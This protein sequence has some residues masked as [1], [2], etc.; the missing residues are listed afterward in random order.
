[1]WDFLATV[2]WD[3]ASCTWDFRRHPS[4]LAPLQST[5]SVSAPESLLSRRDDMGQIRAREEEGHPR[6]S[7]DV[8]RRGLCL[9]LLGLSFPIGKMWLLH[10]PGPGSLGRSDR[11]ESVHSPH[12]QPASL[13]TP[14]PNLKLSPNAVTVPLPRAVSFTALIALGNYLVFCL[15][16][17]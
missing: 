17:V 8:K 15:Y 6:T 10:Q 16:S 11:Y 4:P 14:P 9:G 13:T 5:H 1:M 7:L 3:C 12:P 2:V